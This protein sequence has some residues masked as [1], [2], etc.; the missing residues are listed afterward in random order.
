MDI[1]SA[2]MYVLH[3]CVWYLNWSE[4]GNGSLETAVIDSLKPPSGC[5]ELNLAL[6]EE[7]FTQL[8]KLLT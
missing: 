1:L 4:E 6:P 3:M 5:W 7:P 2:H 8:Q